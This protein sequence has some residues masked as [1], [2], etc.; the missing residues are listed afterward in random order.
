M[1]QA[2]HILME[3]VFQEKLRNKLDSDLGIKPSVG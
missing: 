2:H 1:L 3:E